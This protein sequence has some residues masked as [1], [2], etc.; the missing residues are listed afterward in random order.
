MPIRSPRRRRSTVATVLAAASF[1]ALARSPQRAH[2]DGS[3]VE[4]TSA[5]AST[6]ATAT[7]TATATTT[8][9]TIAS[10]PVPAVSS[11]TPVAPI[12]AAHASGPPTI[13]YVL[14]GVGLVA[15]GSFTYFGLSGRSDVSSLRASCGLYCSDSDVSAAHR[16]L[17]VADASL[18]DLGEHRLG[19]GGLS[20]LF[21]FQINAIGDVR[22]VP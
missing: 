11:A 22:L 7:A 2:A 3:L 9:T 18:L 6:S 14:G 19:I 12:L 15:L 10:A 16:K 20:H 17:Y 8:A 1:V 13:A 4:A 5:S 21:G